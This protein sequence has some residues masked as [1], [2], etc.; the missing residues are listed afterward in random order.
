VR[1]GSPPARTGGVYAAWNGTR[2]P[3][4][5]EAVLDEGR[6]RR[7]S[8]SG[9]LL[10]NVGDGSGRVA[11]QAGRGTEEPAALWTLGSWRRSTDA[12]RPAVRAAARVISRP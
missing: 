11:G 10:L 6:G 4:T 1:S 12:M 9:S 5:K 3:T 7:P 2:R 8:A